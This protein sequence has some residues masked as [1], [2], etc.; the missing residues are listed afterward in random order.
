CDGGDGGDFLQTATSM[1]PGKAMRHGK[2]PD[3]SDDDGDENMEVTSDV[4]DAVGGSDSGGSGGGPHS[5]GLTRRN[6]MAQQQQQ[7]QSADAQISSNASISTQDAST[8]HARP[9]QLDASFAKHRFDK[10]VADLMAA[11]TPYF[12]PHAHVSFRMLEPPFVGCAPDVHKALMC[13]VRPTDGAYGGTP[14]SFRICL[15]EAYPFK[16]PR[17]EALSPLFHPNVNPATGAVAFPMLERDW[18]PVCTLQIV[19][20][21]LVLLFVEPNLEHVVNLEA[22]ELLR[23]APALF[24]QRVNHDKSSLVKASGDQGA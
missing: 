23:S 7:Q 6:I 3:C 8:V 5:G 4:E 10:D 20:L 13:S 24:L 19:V 22:A 14:W 1:K 16:P 9:R 2:R 11:R 18:S 15:P 21:G 12:M 17:I